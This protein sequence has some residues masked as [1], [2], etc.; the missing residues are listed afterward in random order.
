VE[1]GTQ[2][3][4]QM[5]MPNFAGTFAEYNTKASQPEHL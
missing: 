2:I 4:E 3:E 5:A 1:L